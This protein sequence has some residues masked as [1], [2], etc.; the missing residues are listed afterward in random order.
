MYSEAHNTTH[1]R[2]RLQDDLRVNQL[3]DHRLL[4]EASYT[5]GQDTT[6]QAEEV[7]RDALHLNTVNG[8]V[9]AYTGDNAKQLAW[10]FNNTIKEQVKKATREQV[11]AEVVEHAEGL[12]VQGSMLTLAAK[13]KQDILWKSVMFPPKSGT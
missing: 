5:R 9:P 4:R 11:Q 3:I 2:T 6:T 12:L 1:A 8:Q 7:Y 13:E 10:K